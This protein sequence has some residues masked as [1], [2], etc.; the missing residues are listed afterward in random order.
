MK[1]GAPQTQSSSRADTEGCKQP[2]W[3]STSDTD[4]RAERFLIMHLGWLL[5][6]YGGNVAREL[7]NDDTGQAGLARNR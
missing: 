4:V 1:E 3:G 7:L 5:A 6:G 2:A